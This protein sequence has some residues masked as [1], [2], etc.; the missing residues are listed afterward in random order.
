MWYWQAQGMAGRPVIYAGMLDAFRQI[1]SREGIP[2]C[3][4]ANAVAHAN[5]C[6]TPPSL[7]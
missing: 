7:Q 1:L 4:T 2:Q 6:N 5:A 3:I